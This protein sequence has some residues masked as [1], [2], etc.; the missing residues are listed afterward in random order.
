MIHIENL[1]VLYPDKTKAIDNLSFEISDGE[2]VAIVGANGA[3]K[4]SLLLTLSG[5]LLPAKGRISIHGTTLQ[6]EHIHTIRRQVGMVFQNPD[7]QLF[8]PVIMDD[9]AF[10]PRNYGFNEKEASEKASAALDR[11]GISHLKD[12]SPLKLSGGEKRTAA[13]A[14]ILAMEPSIMLFD[15]PSSF[16]DPKA[17]R[18]LITILKSL[19]IT[20]IIA[21]HD[22][23]LTAEL[24][25]RIIVLYQGGLFFDGKPEDILYDE[26]KM[27]ECGLEAIER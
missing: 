17:R 21:T 13:I 15:E 8:M 4:T 1:T 7:D 14:T 18:N 12:R 11:L 16:L 20:K 10:G 19:R 9:V 5:V 24:C 27:D 25:S 22:L 3:G 6:R 26:K 2:S 23:S